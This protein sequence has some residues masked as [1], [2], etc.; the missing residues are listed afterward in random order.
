M[1]LESI[2]RCWREE[3]QSVPPRLEEETAM[4]ML[5]NRAIDL[6]RQV[7]RRLRREAGYYVP[8]LAVSAAS[9]A[10]GFT[11]NR[12]LA[13][14]V[15]VVML[16]AVMTTLWWAEH[17]TKEAPLDRS[18]REALIDLGSKRCQPVYRQLRP[19]PSSRRCAG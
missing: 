10:G 11:S 19:G 7:R 8:M 17:R 2:K 5:T 18:L 16:G 9:L 12:M 15:V 13:A 6:R 4:R 3:T 14:I 1:D